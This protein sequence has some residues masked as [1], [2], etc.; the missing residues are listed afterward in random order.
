M[1]PAMAKMTADATVSNKGKGNGRR[2]GQGGKGAGKHDPDR[3]ETKKLQKDIKAF[4]NPHI[5]SLCI[6][7]RV[8]FRYAHISFCFIFTRM[9]LRLRDMGQKAREAGLGLTSLGIPHQDV[10][11]SGM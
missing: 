9:I 11:V 10:Q 7:C 4:L 5:S 6:S 1:E 3:E 8:W 2:S